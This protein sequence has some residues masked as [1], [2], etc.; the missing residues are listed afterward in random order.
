MVDGITFFT[1]IAWVTLGSGAWLTTGT[2]SAS[3]PGHIIPGGHLTH[4]LD[5]GVDTT[6]LEYPGRHVQLACADDIGGEMLLYGHRFI[7]PYR[8]QNPARHPSHAG[9]P[10]MLSHTHGHAG[11]SEVPW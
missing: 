11:V 5:P 4:R 7:A 10:Y 8:H 2:G 1:M 9:P 6:S 3:P